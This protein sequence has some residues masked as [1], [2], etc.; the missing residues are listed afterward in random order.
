ML[1]HP[2]GRF[3]TTTGRLR[4]ARPGRPDASNCR[5]IANAALQKSLAASCAAA[6]YEIP[7]ICTPLELIEEQRSD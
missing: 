2:S 7:V 4:V 3:S 1:S 5:H 6:G